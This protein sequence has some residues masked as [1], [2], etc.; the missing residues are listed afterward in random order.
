MKTSGLKNFLLSIQDSPILSQLPKI[1]EFKQTWQAEE[2]QVDDI[3]LVG[4]EITS[5]TKKSKE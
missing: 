4:F 2:E 5:N 3:L 1:N